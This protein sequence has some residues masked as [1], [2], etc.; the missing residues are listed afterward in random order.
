MIP[1]ITDPL[2][3]HWKQ[4]V[5]IRMAP[6]NDTHV[7]LTRAQ[8]RQLAEYSTSTPTGVY[9]GKCWS[10]YH[11]DGNPNLPRKHL[12]GQWYLK[13]YRASKDPRYCNIE[14][15]TILF[16]K[17]KPE[18]PTLH[19]MVKAL[20]AVR[21]ELGHHTMLSMLHGIASVRIAADV[22]PRLYEAVMKRAK[23]AVLFHQLKKE[24]TK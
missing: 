16:G 6:M 10:S 14:V 24:Q 12:A 5:D 18:P 20:V 1:P 9:P 19:N 4:P 22:P 13:W 23:D 15:R 8:L 11:V 21:A 2:G 17:L 7:L 3:K